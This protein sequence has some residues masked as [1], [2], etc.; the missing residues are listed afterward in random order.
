MI[1]N[2]KRSF[3]KNFG[4]ILIPIFFPIFIFSQ[5]SENERIDSLKQ[6]LRDKNYFEQTPILLELANLYIYESR[7]STLSYVK[8]LESRITQSSKYKVNFE[9]LKLKQ[10]I[11]DNDS[12]YSEKSLDIFKKKYLSKCSQKEYL[13]F[14]YLEAGF[15]ETKDRKIALEI[16]NKVLKKYG[17]LKLI[18]IA[19]FYVFKSTQLNALSRHSESI[20]SIESALHIYRKLKSWNQ[21][22]R[23]YMFLS[24]QYMALKDFDKARI[25]IQKSINIKGFDKNVLEF[26]DEHIALGKILYFQEKYKEAIA[27]FNI[28][29]EKN[30]KLGFAD[31]YNDI[32]Y[33][34]SLCMYN[35]KQYEKVIGICL[36][37]FKKD[38]F[39][40]E[41]RF[42]INYLLILN[43][44]KLNKFKEAKIYLDQTNQLIKETPDPLP[45]ADLLAFMKVS[46]DTEKGLGN[47]TKALDISGKYIKI[48]QEHYD[49]INYAKI[50]ASHTSFD[51][52]EKELELKDLKIKSTTNKLKLEKLKN[53]RVLLWVLIIFGGI[54]LSGI[55]LFSKKLSTKNHELT[56][57]NVI[58]EKSKSRIE[59]LLKEL[60]HRTKNNLQLIIS[61]LKIQARSNKYIDI[62]EFIEVN[63]NRISS[64][65]MIHQYLYLNDALNNKIS[66]K[67][68]SEDLI[69]AIKHTFEYKANIDFVLK[70][71]DISCSVNEA[72]ALG[73]IINELATNSLKYAF[74][75]N[76]EGKI[77][78]EIN[79]G[80]TGMIQL[81]Y[82][83]NGIGFE[84]KDIKQGSFGI[85]LVNLLVAQI[86]GKVFFTNDNGAKYQ[87]NIPLSTMNES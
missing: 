16:T 27:V 32:L 20:Q 4:I 74:K 38:Y 59:M 69:N 51:L 86:Q 36:N 67:N 39:I 65:A 70:S 58:I 18:I 14:K 43:Y 54:T 41:M 25:T 26:I 48:H 56:H 71:Q 81:I 40:E 64:M 29:E 62:N 9:L 75:E 84:A 8:I 44:N 17:H 5:N 24:Y 12:K 3:L 60:Q 49:S 85:S 23:A 46:I 78:I 63:R 73:L 68:Y 50:A 22:S 61:M 42:T 28:A 83:D 77:D 13:D 34:R 76:Q 47:T 15:Y 35:L 82:K 33:Y 53:E 87:I 79:V 19:D 57:Q 52:A 55:T 66:L 7:D 80:T 21:I 45:I 30:K 6:A 31:I 11:F 1:E 72:V 37:E 2:F 10:I